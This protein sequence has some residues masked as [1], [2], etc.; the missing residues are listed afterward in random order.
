MRAIGGGH[1]ILPRIVHGRS[2]FHWF[3]RVAGRLWEWRRR[4]QWRRRLAT[5]NDHM[6]KDIGISRA[7]AWREARKPFWQE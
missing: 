4:H 7:D 1:A 5:L 2:P 6:R 3:G